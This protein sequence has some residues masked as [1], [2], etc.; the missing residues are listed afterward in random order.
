VA[1]V[2]PGNSPILVFSSLPGPDACVAGWTTGSAPG[3]LSSRGHT[4][5][6]SEVEDGQWHLL[7]F[8]RRGDLRRF[9]VDGVLA[10]EST[11]SAEPTA[12]TDF[13][14]FEYPGAATF[15]G[16]LSELLVYEVAQSDTEIAE[17]NHLLLEKWKSHF[18]DRERDLVVFVGNSITTGMF[19]G[20]GKTWSAKTAAR[21]PSLKR[22]YNVSKGGITTDG[23]TALAPTMIDPLLARSSGR[24]TLIF[25]EGTNDLVVNQSE[26]A[27]AA[28]NIKAFCEARKKAG[29]DQIIVLN[30]LPR[31][32]GG[33]FESR[34][35]ALNE[36]LA[37]HASEYGI[38][39]LIDL[40]AVPE[41]GAAGKELD[42][43]FYPD[44][45][46]LNEKGQ[47]AVALAVAPVLQAGLER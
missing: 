8:W 20:N 5:A 44:G 26:P 4:Q 42:Q 34:R 19:C 41:I 39:A 14:L 31:Q 2:A 33:D 23:L 7:T 32:A 40:A 27:D 47:E 30:V 46:H 17:L 43:E 6:F 9:Y 28:S 1:K 37:T 13:I 21:I 36:L 24:K 3:F 16:S 22:W 29:W 12:I 45:V 38:D 15:L 35:I 10:G 11:A 25:W 18:P